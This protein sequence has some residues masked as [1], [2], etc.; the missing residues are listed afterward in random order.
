M[1]DTLHDFM[2]EDTGLVFTTFES[3]TE[4]GGLMVKPRKDGCAKLL[5]LYPP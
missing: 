2:V 4:V 3:V 5:H 1:V